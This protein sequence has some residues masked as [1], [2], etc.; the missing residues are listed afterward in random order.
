MPALIPMP[1][2]TL[3]HLRYAVMEIAIVFAVVLSVKEIADNMAITGAGSIAMW[4]GLVQ[5]WV[6]SC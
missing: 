4:S 1:Y 2:C 6:K 3:N 5:H